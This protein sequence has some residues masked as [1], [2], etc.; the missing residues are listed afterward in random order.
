MRWDPPA[1]NGGAPV[2][3]YILELDDGQQGWR[4]VFQVR[5][6]LIA[7]RIITFLIS[8]CAPLSYDFTFLGVS[9]QNRETGLLFENRE[10]R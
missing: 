10:I 2:F 5:N 3:E 6:Y 7:I 8:L 4:T 9:F 1:E